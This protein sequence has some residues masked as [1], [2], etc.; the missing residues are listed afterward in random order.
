MADRAVPSSASH[1]PAMP[2][3]GHTTAARAGPGGV[4]TTAPVEML[5]SGV[6]ICS[7]LAFLPGDQPTALENPSMNK[8][9]RHAVVAA[10]AAVAIGTVLRLLSDFVNAPDLGEAG[11]TLAAAIGIILFFIFYLRGANRRTAT[12]DTEARERALA[13]ACPADRA[14]VYFVRSGLA[15]AAVGVDIRVDGQT[16]AQIK[17]PRFTCVT[18]APGLRTLEACVGDGRSSL[19]PASAVMSAT[20]T[21]GSVTLLHIGT[22]RSMLKTAL[23][24]EPWS[25]ETAKARLKKIGMVLADSSAA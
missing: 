16:V 20:V 25:I 8:L 7:N 12:G 2:P 14:L 6:R 1:T 4:M 22:R 19:A 5:G 17:S 23:V 21:A 9:L 13:F 15:G 24:F 3:S 11:W 10:L 18:I